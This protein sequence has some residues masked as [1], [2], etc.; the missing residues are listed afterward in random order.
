MQNPP[1]ILKK[2][3]ARKVEEVAEAK[4]QKSLEQIIEEAKQALPTRGFVTA[5]KNKIKQGLPAIIAEVK[6]ASPSKG[7]FRINFQPIEIAKNY[8]NN[9]AAC[10]SVLTDRDFFQG[11]ETYLKQARN[12]CGLPVLCKDFLIDPYQVYLARSW[13]ADCIL[14]IAAILTDDQMQALSDLAIH[15]EMDVLVEVHDQNEL[16]RA[17][18]LPLSMIGIN[19]RDL[20]TFET[21]LETTLNL[22]NFIS[23]DRLIVTESGILTREDV[24]LMRN[25]NIQAFLVG[26]AFM[27]TSDEGSALKQLFFCSDQI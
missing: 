27:K 6:K 4:A 3:V 13:N 14:L 1:D 22:K 19:N 2:I 7:T 26:E 10:L 20:R 23:D 8:Q 25:A 12:A 21:Q 15:L 16:E 11:H 5:L 9:G 24:V 17:L 18:K